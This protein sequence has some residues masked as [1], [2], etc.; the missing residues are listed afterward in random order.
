MIDGQGLREDIA[1]DIC[2]F[3]GVDDQPM[4]SKLVKVNP[5]R[6]QDMVTN[7]DEFASVIAKSEFASLL[8]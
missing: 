4:H 7:Y 3:L 1:R 5:E 8:D 2:R 6:L